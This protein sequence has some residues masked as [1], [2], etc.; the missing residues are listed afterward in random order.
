[1]VDTANLALPLL[2]AAQSQKHVTHNEALMRLD[3][4]IQI[5]VLAMAANAPV[6]P[7]N[8]GDRY[9]VGSAPTADFAG[10]AGKLASY[11]GTA[12]RFLS[13]KAGW[14]LFNTSDG[15]V[16][17]FDGAAW[18]KIT[19]A[20]T[21]LQ[22]LSGLG[23][24]TSSDSYNSFSA[25]LNSA[26]FAARG[27]GEG[28]SGDV[29]VTLNKQASG[30]TA[31]Q[32]YQTGWS[33]RAETGLSGDD[34]WHLKVSADGSTWREVMVANAATGSARLDLLLS[35]RASQGNS[36][37]F[38]SDFDGSAATG[39]VLSDVSSTTSATAINFRKGGGSVGAI[40]LAATGTS[41]LT[42]SDYRLKQ[43]IER[44]ADGL[45]RL[46]L[47]KPCRFAF[48]AAPEQK[49]DGFIA[50]EVAGVVPEAVEGV[51]DAVDAEGA[52]IPRSVDLA[53]L[54]PLLV[55]AVQT[56]S[57]RLDQLEVKR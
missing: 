7:A 6:T 13:P 9:L 28:G 42:T 40:K 39:I 11:D 51:K 1:M 22:N 14:I 41:F 15:L 2:A 33:G 23:I 20:V 10:Q 55:A 3:G 44:L 56:L 32:L 48:K 24:G 43:D 21:Q 50:H 19:D 31:S 27:T 54:V 47:L 29:R 49:V 4:L 37:K 26:L 34:N 52:I 53:R 8:A 16:Y 5:A 17:V 36:G 45:S 25:K 57:A 30:N 38:E 35:G 18:H 46:T 12:W